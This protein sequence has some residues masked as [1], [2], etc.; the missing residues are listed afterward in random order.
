LGFGSGVSGETDP[1]Y[2]MIFVNDWGPYERLEGFKEQVEII[3]NFLRNR[4]INYDGKYYSIKNAYIY[5]LPIQKLRRSLTI[6]AM[7]K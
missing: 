6:T 7:G 1:I 3:D 5:P 2:K 4:E